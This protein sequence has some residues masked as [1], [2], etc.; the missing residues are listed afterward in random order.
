MFRNTFRILINDKSNLKT[1]KKLLE[2]L[3]K[4]YNFVDNKK[5]ISYDN[6]MES[7]IDIIKKH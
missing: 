2:L 4:R 5:L 7:I 3:L 1:K 6:K